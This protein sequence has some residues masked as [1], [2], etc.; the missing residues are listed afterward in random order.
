MRQLRPQKE[1]NIIEN[2]Q[3]LWLPSLQILDGKDSLALLDLRDVS[4]RIERLGSPLPDDD[5]VLSEGNYTEQLL[6]VNL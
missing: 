4:L 5:T 3:E 1:L 6:D 2:Y